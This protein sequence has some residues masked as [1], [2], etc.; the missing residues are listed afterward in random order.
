M[1]HQTTMATT[2]DRVGVLIVHGMGSQPRDFADSFISELG[3]RLHALGVPAE[4]TVCQAAYWA[5][6]LDRQ[7]SELW[8]RVA[9]Q[10]V[11]WRP[12]R[13]FV[14]SA[15]GDALAYRASPTAVYTTYKRIHGRIADE[16]AGLERAVGRDGAPLVIIGH[17]LGSVIASDHVWDEQVGR[18][19]GTSPF[20][21]A[22][23]LAGMI[24]FGSTLPLFGLDVD[25]IVPIRFPGAALTPQQKSNARWLNFYDA[26]D[27]L[28]YPLKATAYGYE[29]TV[30]EDVVVDSGPPILDK[31]PLSHVYY[32]SNPD[33]I[34]RTAIL[35]RELVTSRTT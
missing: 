8:G 20:T 19:F 1:L 4:A 9:L 17:S 26:A 33:V 18:G 35:I 11:S 3:S 30:D 23:T 5:D 31:T 13:R 27:V 14:V 32:W 7:E 12:L 28:G 16:L 2:A 34:N 25:P 21:R 15:V 10:P 24:T 6:V 29:Y 22:E